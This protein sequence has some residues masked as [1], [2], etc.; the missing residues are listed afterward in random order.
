MGLVLLHF[1]IASPVRGVDVAPW[2]LM[3]PATPLFR[4]SRFLLNCWWH[5]LQ[6]FVG[7]EGGLF[8]LASL[9]G[10]GHILPS[11]CLLLLFIA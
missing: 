8:V 7:L 5:L 3:V 10:C 9:L 2:R 1:G 4:R 6:G 11:C